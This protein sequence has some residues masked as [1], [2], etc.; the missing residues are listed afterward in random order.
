VT[1]L[2]A[3]PWFYAAAVPSVILVGLSKGGFG[4]TVGFV[5]V[6]L[7]ALVMSPIQAAAILLPILVFMDIVS[8]WTW[9]GVFDRDVLS[10]MLPGSL[11]GIGVGWLTAASVTADAI[12]LVVGVVAIVFVLRWLMQLYRHGASHSA[13]PNR[14]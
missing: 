11:L 1:E 7:M 8:L 3:D 10:S 12:R 4:G 14:V 2:L 13:R 9:R 6:P 5:G